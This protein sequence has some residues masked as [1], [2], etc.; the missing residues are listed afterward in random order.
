MPRL[1]D[2]ALIVTGVAPPSQAG[3]VCFIQMKDLDPDRRELVR[4]AAPTAGR[5]TPVKRGDVLIPSRGERNLAIRPDAELLGAYPSLDVYLLR[6]DE[7]RLDPDYLAAFLSLPEVG[8]ALRASTAGASLPRIPKEALSELAVP[9]PP[10]ER[11]RAIGGLAACAREHSLLAARLRD[12]E[13]RLA[14]AYI[15][16]AFPTIEA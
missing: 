15:A 1:A 3:G 10:L 11:Q 6:P 8:A 9:T 13:A 2:L 14:A 5:A 7:L 4:R 12:A 16:S